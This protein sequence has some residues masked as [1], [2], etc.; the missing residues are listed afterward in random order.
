MGTARERPARLRGEHVVN[1]VEFVQGIRLKFD[2]SKG[3]NAAFAA[4]HDEVLAAVVGDAGRR[5]VI[6]AGYDDI[7]D[8]GVCPNR[9]EACESAEYRE[10][11]RRVAA[12]YGVAVGE[13]YLSARL[14][15]V[16]MG[17]CSRRDGA[18]RRR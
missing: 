12:R 9:K 6:V 17:E 16:V 3:Y 2:E 11:D 5:V 7:C 15:D 4:A 10:N 18:D 8:C 14:L 13:E 1:L